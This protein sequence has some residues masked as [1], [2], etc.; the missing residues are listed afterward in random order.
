MS[1]AAL[2]HVVHA[3]ATVA[4]ESAI[5]MILTD[6]FYG[7]MIRKMQAEGRSAPTAE[8]L[9]AAKA[10]ALSSVERLRDSIAAKR[11]EVKA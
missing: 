4:I 2:S 7:E 8:E 3:V 10:R 11:E 1:S 6:Q 5:E 9:A